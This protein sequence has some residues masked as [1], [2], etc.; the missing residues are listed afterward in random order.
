MQK[1]VGVNLNGNAY[2]IEEQGYAALQAYLERAEARLATNP[3][4]AEI[5]ADLEQAIADKF[6]GVLRP[7]KTVV[8]AAEVERILAEMGPVDDGDAQ[9]ATGTANT[10]GARSSDG[11]AGSAATK[12][13]YQIREGAMI[14]GVCNGIAAYLNVDVTIVR[15]AFVL[16]AVLTRGAW[17]LVYAG[18]M[19]VIPYAETSEERAAASGRPFTAQ[20]LID[21]A[22]RNYADFRNNKDWKQHWRRQRRAWKRQWRY[23]VHRTAWGPAAAQAAYASQVTAGAAAPVFGLIHAALALALVLALISLATT[24]M[25]FGYALPSGLPL[26]AAF[27]I[28]ILIYQT[29]ASPFIAARHAAMAG[30]GPMPFGWLGPLLGLLWLGLIAFSIW[31]GYHNVQPVRDFIQQLPAWWQTVVAQ[32]RK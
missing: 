9:T 20:E 3:D 27:V 29:I 15:I 7:H 31:W 13:L 2:Q 17:L 23:A 25:L 21:Q 22:K 30:Y 4:R 5:V 10:E 24:H 8:S 1:V 14:S 18:M 19:F 16:L 11:K 28:V 12:R 26:W 32:L 6:A